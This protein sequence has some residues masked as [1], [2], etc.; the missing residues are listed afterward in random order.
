MCLGKLPVIAPAWLPAL[1]KISLQILFAPEESKIPTF[2]ND[3]EGSKNSADWKNGDKNE[4]T[5]RV[6]KTVY[7][8]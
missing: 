2:M 6:K 5:E 8:L 4:Q 7:L 1:L 3:Q